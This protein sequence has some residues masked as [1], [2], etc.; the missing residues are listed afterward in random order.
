MFFFLSTWKQRTSVIP[1]VP[2][3]VF[4]ASESNKVWKRM[5]HRAERDRGGGKSDSLKLM[6][7]SSNA[8]TDGTDDV[9]MLFIA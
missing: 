6:Q 8:G 4:S 1:K 9:Q 5:E 7:M 3:Y 2:N